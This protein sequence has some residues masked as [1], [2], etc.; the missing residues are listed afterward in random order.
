MVDFLLCGGL[1]IR[2]YK[3]KGIR[4]CYTAV[5]RAARENYAYTSNVTF[6]SYMPI[7]TYECVCVC[8]PICVGTCGRCM[9][10]C[11]SKPKMDA[12]SLLSSMNQGLSTLQ[13]SESRK[14]A[15]SGESPSLPPE[16][17][18]YRPTPTPIWHLCGLWDLN[19]HPHTYGANTL[20]TTEP[21]SQ[22]LSCYFS[23]PKLNMHF[24]R[25]IM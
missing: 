6:L 17:W 22:P 12:G 14:S 11:M 16:Q 5:C 15:C 13:D 9:C 2:S 1:Y 3:G 8:V 7:C 25:W 10:T 20:S 18:I 21:F 4:P 23:K 24:Q 19:S